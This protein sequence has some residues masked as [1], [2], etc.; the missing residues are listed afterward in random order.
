MT[1]LFPCVLVMN[2]HPPF[3]QRWAYFRDDW[4]HALTKICT[5]FGHR[6]C[7]LT[8]KEIE[9]LT[10][11]IRFLIQIRKINRFCVGGMGDFDKIVTSTIKKL[12]KEFPNIK[13][14]LALAY[15]PKNKIKYEKDLNVYDNVF[16]PENIELSPPKFAIV[17]RNKLMVIRSD[18]IICYIRYQF[19]GAYNAVNFAKSQNK[20][21]FNIAT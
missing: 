6:E 4:S 20:T 1:G 16:L 21:I 9:K 2:I 5:F 18:Y 7:I 12:K 10:N 11:T 8:P 17:K 15:L 14:E 13:L 3:V 19:G